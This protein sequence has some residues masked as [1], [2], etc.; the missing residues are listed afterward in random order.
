MS[1]LPPKP[2]FAAIEAAAQRSVNRRTLILTLI[3]NLAYSWSNNE[4]M[5]IYVLMLLM[6]TDEISAAVVF[7]TLNTTRARLDLVERLAKIKIKDKVIDKTLERMVARFNQFTRLRNEFN[8]CMYSVDQSGEITHTQSIRVQEVRG[9]MQLG[10]VRKMHGA[11][12]QEMSD[13]I[14][15]LTQLNR[16]IWDFLPRLQAHL[17]EVHAEVD[18]TGASELR[19]I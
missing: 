12:I 11:R 1:R 5:F 16:E 18:R 6:N 8:H 15:G 7:A 4:S 9:Q 13:A 2:D 17:E 3:G 10:I 14:R 19:D